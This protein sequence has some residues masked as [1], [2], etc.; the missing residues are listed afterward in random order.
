VCCLEGL[1]SGVEKLAAIALE[2][3]GSIVFEERKVLAASCLEERSLHAV[4]ITLPPLAQNQPSGSQR[5]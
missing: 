5:L 3:N 1:A 2:R 4:T